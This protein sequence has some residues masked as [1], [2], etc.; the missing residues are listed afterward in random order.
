MTFSISNSGSCC[1]WCNGLEVEE[2][3]S[4]ALSLSSLAKASTYS[5]A[6]R[7]STD[8]NS[9]MTSVD[10][11]DAINELFA[12]CYGDSSS[13]APAETSVSEEKESRVYTAIKA[14][15]NAICSVFSRIWQA[16]VYL[17]DQVFGSKEVEENIW[18]LDSM[19]RPIDY[20]IY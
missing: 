12:S 19:G 15:C 5:T 3:C 2:G 4:N 8:S 20:S 7:S 17:F 16:M 18:N 13:R 6:R 14:V 1:D 11:R 9:S 10:M